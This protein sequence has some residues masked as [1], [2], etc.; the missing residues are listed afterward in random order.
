MSQ[1]VRD[2]RVAMIYEGAN[3]IQALDLVARKLPAEGGR[4]FMAFLELLRA[5]QSEAEGPDELA[6]MRLALEAAAKD[7]RAAAMHFL[8]RGAQAPAEALAGAT[9]FMHLFG[10]ACLGLMWLRMARA[11]LSA[12]ARG[13]G[14]PA[15]L[16]AKLA[17]ARCYA[18][19]QLPATAL[20][21]ARI[22]SGAGP[23]MALDPASL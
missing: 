5:A 23:V 3:G 10:H 7:L 18:A 15:F 21:L 19:R 20:H 6:P 9:D 12:L 14:D 17:T 11:A 4:A 22:T 16:R 2:A 8:A 1:Y 13:E